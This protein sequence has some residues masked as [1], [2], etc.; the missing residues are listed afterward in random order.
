MMNA[1]KGVRF[2]HVCLAVRD[3]HEAMADYRDI[4]SAVSPQHLI[5]PTVYYEDFGAG[6]ERLSFATFPDPA[7]GVEIQFLQAKTPGTPLYERVA[8][9]GEHVHHLCFTAPQV[10]TMV[11]ELNHLGIGIVPQ[12]YSMDPQM[13]WQE[14]TF[15]HPKKSHGVLIELANHYRS[16]DTKWHPGPG[17]A[18]RVGG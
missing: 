18:P 12:G 4:L 8:K 7:G 6:D 10:R 17:V 11:E 3:I 15:V 2:A 1:D 13:P 16:I 14:W 9:H 5:E